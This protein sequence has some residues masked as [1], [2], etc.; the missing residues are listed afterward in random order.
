MRGHLG[1]LRLGPKHR[2][3]FAPSRSAVVALLAAVAVCL[4]YSASLATADAGAFKVRV[5][6]L[7]TFDGETQPW[8]THETWP[9]EFR[10]TG[11]HGPVL[12][13]KTGLCVT[14]TG[15][16][17]SNSGPSLTAILHA[18][19]LNLHDAYFIVAGIAGTRPD[20][21][22]EGFKGT[23]GFAGIANWIVDG[24]LGTQFD[25]RDVTPSDPADVREFAWYY[26]QDYE[27]AQFH[28]NEALAAL[29]YEA[30]KDVPLADDLDAQLARNVY[31]SQAGMKPFVARCDTVGADD[32]FSGPH[33][34]DRMDHIVRFRSSGAATKCTSELED[35]GFANALRLHGLLDRLVVVRTA[36]DF[37]TP[38]SGVSTFD[39]LTKIGYPGYA[40]STENAYRVAAAI[41]RDLIGQ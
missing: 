15:T 13:Q 12:C 37:E 29:A 34:A 39:L 38:P 22:A 1:Y 21:G 20:A 26:L 31:P 35:P 18:P 3:A 30:S 14:T 32:F 27:N 8:L 5:L 7:T 28:L 6:V 24:D 2:P 10:V 9:R 25:Y 41:A 4:I 40:I 16:G 17:K 33:D 23:L 11:A 36:S 19:Q